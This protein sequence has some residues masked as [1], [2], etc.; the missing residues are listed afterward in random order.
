MTGLKQNPAYEPADF[1]IMELNAHI[2]I[3]PFCGFPT[4]VVWVHGHGQCMICKSVLDECC[5]GEQQSEKA[6]EEK[7]KSKKKNEKHD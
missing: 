7:K 6:K 5:R 3:C 2:I 4:Q 1:F